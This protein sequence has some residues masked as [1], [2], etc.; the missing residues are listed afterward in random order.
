M[1]I[2]EHVRY[3]SR[4]E[5]A[6]NNSFTKTE[7]KEI[8]DFARKHYVDVAPGWNTPGHCGWLVQHV[9]QDLQEDGD[10]KTLCTSNPEGMRILKDVGQELLDL[11]EPTYFHLGG[12]EVT[13]GWNRVTKRTCKLCTGKPKNQLL[14][15]HWGELARFFEQRGV[16]PILFDDMLSV[17]WNGGP[18]YHCAEILPK[19]PRNLIIATWG[20]FPLSVPPANLR[21][22]GFVPWWL[23]T[24]FSA[25]KMD[26]F[27]AMW[28]NYDACG[29]SETTTWVWSNFTHHN[30][31]RQCGYS[32]PSLHANAACCWKPEVAA[33]G[34]GPMIRS[35]GIHWSNVMQVPDW[36]ARKLA[37][38]PVSI[39]AACNDSTRDAQAGDG[40]GWMDLG[41][42]Q[43]LRSFP[44]GRLS[45]GGIPFERPEA[46]EDCV[47][48]KEGQASQPVKVGGRVLG[49]AFAHTTGANE[50]QTKAL[51]QRFFRKN[52]D[53]LAM[54]VARY[55]VRYADGA[56]ASVPVRIGYDVHL[57]DCNDAARV[58]P[59]PSTYWMGLTSAG[60]QRDRNSPDACVWV[61]EWVNPFPEKTVQD[62]VFVSAGTEAVVVCLGITA[63]E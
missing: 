4:P 35:L 23:S 41:P 33:M 18:P 50:A 58:M 9:H 27:P 8:I 57:W 25:G 6:P 2:S 29:V 1:Q 61:M 22:L 46:K 11:F 62:V 52:T 10:R 39:A 30:Y 26:T 45:V 19:L 17:K 3:D 47:L 55:E 32:T 24:S 51:Y 13:H 42:E 56:S 12:D 38:R 16:R 28:K 60:E 49:F 54:P 59:G 44:N 53:P 34:H 48:L 36:G 63:V 5:L 7:L 31:K 20:T 21:K 14:L 37:Y 15:E 40:K 43:D